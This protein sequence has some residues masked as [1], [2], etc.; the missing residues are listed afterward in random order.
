MSAKVSQ[1]YWD[2]GYEHLDL[3][4]KPETIEFRELFE[5][6]LK[7]QGTC[8]EIGCYP[9]NFLI[10]LGTRFDY[11]VSGI[12]TTSY[13]LSRL[14][15]HLINHGVKVGKF[16]QG[17]FL[18]F[19]SS[20]VYDVVCSFGFIEH[21]SN[22]EEVIERHIR[23]VKPGGILIIS[24]PNFRGLQYIFH[25]LL[26]PAN[27]ERH[28]LKA[29]SLSRW[30][31]VLKRNGMM[32]IYQG[33]Y[34]TADFWVDTPRSRRWAELAIECIKWATKQIDRRVNWPNPLLSPHMIS[35]SQKNACG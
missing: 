3:V 26:D 7:P 1:E 29:M 34:R 12:D 5:R 14:P 19:E 6:H 2:A 35:F 31:R 8:F 33:Y 25:R 15:Q 13:V 23:L 10:Y 18:S 21:F 16:H 28:V 11:V 27:L 24:C 20:D 9:G 17:D 4:Y 32:T 22:L 30:N